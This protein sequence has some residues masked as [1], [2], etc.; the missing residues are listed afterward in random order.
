MDIDI[1]SSWLSFCLP[2]ATAPLKQDMSDVP[3]VSHDVPG[4]HDA[5]GPRV[6]D[7]RDLLHNCGQSSQRQ[8]LPVCP[9]DHS[10][11]QLDH[12][13]LGILQFTSEQ[14]NG[15]L[16]FSRF[17]SLLDKNPMT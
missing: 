15:I 1:N 8:A 16:F 9:G 7:L 6:L 12:H 10:A 5:L 17:F 3:R 4:D 11:A 2:K 14:E 13:A